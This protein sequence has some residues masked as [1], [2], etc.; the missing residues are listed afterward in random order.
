[1]PID[2][3]RFTP[4]QL[5]AALELNNR[6]QAKRS[7]I[8]SACYFDAKYRPSGTGFHAHLAAHLEAVEAG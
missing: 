6:K 3:A 2:P 7:L 8:A 1:M 4:K 5:A